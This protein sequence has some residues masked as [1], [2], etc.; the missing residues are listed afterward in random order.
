MKKIMKVPLFSKLLSYEVLSYLFFGVMTTLVNF[1]VFYVCDRILG[2]KELFDFNLFN[3][4]FKVTLEDVSTFI[5]WIFAVLFAY[6]T[7][8][9]WVFESKSTKPSVILREIVAFFGARIISFILFESIGF[10]LLRNIFLNIGG[11]ETAS[12]WVAKILAAVIVVIF[13][14]IASKLVVFR[15]KKKN[16]EVNSDES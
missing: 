15:N 2:S 7:N 12:K 4:E 11:S 10:M 8:K 3:Y 6:V 1:V 5:A 14:Y 13:N 9:L 16:T